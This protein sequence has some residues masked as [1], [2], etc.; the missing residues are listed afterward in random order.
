MDAVV[1]H[2]RSDDSWDVREGQFWRECRDSIRRRDVVL[3][4]DQLHVTEKEER[5][6]KDPAKAGQHMLDGEIQVK[7]D[8]IEVEAGVWDDGDLVTFDEVAEEPGNLSQDGH[9]NMKKMVSKYAKDIRKERAESVSSDEA[10]ETLNSWFDEVK[11][12]LSGEERDSVRSNV[13]IITG[14]KQ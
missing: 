12:D 4:I 3:A 9:E 8:D 2:S 1:S 6:A 11:D 14:G 10:E 5:W 7:G 13:E